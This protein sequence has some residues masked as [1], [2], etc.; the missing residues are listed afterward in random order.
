MYADLAV[1]TRKP[2]HTL[3]EKH[4]DQK[5]EKF[6]QETAQKH[7]GHDA[8]STA[9]SWSERLKTSQDRWKRWWKWVLSPRGKSFRQKFYLS[10][11]VSIVLLGGIAVYLV[12]FTSFDIRQWAWGGAVFN[13][14][15]FS[16]QSLSL[17]DISAGDPEVAEL[18]TDLTYAYPNADVVNISNE[19]FD[20]EAIAF[21]AFEPELNQTVIFIR[22]ENMPV[23]VDSIP[24]IW[25]TTNTGL[26][27]EAGVGEILIE[28]GTV[29]GYFLTTLEG[30]DEYYQSLSLTY[31]YF[32]N[33]LEPSPAFFTVNFADDEIEVEI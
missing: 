19:E 3:L 32:L 24:K 18:F 14:E 29:V 13:Q 2:I 4:A 25:I 5:A 31:D 30:P 11:I 26:D 21:K 22:V 28:S 20:V 7:A 8:D 15:Q 10:S 1:A 6:P 33:Q 12:S 9:P 27:I 16:R 23:L 17:D